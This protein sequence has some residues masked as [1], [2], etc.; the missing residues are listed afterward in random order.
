[1]QIEEEIRIWYLNVTATANHSGFDWMTRTGKEVNTV[2]LGVTSIG[3]GEALPID[4]KI[5]GE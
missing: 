1:M 3:K 5:S 4:N 2:P